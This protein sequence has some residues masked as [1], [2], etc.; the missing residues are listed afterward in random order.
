MICLNPLCEN[1]AKIKYC[2][3]SCSAIVNNSKFPKRGNGLPRHCLFCKTLI[4]SKNSRTKF[5]SRDCS[6]KFAHNERVNNWLT[7]K[8]SGTTRDGSPSSFVR[9]FLLEEVNY[10]C[11]ECGWN[12]VNPKLKAPTLTID[13]ID[14]NWLNNSRSN[15]IVLCYNCHT[16]TPTF[17]SLNQGNE[18]VTLSRDKMQQI[19]S[20]NVHHFYGYAEGYAPPI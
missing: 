5:C 8:I 16:L 10:S 12:K 15:L 3:N 20:G 9:R 13:H 19:G 7:G 18:L 1:T 6:F 14:G 11:T 4:T 17:G 2:S